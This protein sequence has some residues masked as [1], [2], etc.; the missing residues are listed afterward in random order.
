[1][2]FCFITSPSRS[3]GAPAIIST[4]RTILTAKRLWN[5][6]RLLENPEVTIEDGRIA[7][8]V[9]PPAGARLGHALNGLL[10]YPEATLARAFLDVH[11]HG[12]AGHDVMEAAPEALHAVGG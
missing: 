10:D 4:M 11:V 2:F 1:G 7:S 8:I 5:G 3:A 12:A 9:S 6:T